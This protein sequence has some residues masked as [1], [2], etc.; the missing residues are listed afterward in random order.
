M[1]RSATLDARPNVCPKCS[2]SLIKDL[3]DDRKCLQC[4]FVAYARP[5][6]PVDPAKRER[7]PTYK[8]MNL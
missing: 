6:E 1:T 4:G 2:G 5:P 8:G 3:D 7:S